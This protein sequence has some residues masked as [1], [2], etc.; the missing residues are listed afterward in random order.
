MK[1]KNRVIFGT[2]PETIK[3]A[4]WV[5]KFSEYSQN[6]ETKMWCVTAEHLEMLYQVSRVFNTVPDFVPVHEDT[7]TTMTIG[8][9]NFYSGA[10]VFYVEADLRIFD[11]RPPFPEEINRS[12]VLGVSNYHFVSTETLRNN[13][14]N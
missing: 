8:L 6:F 2:H 14:I 4:Q 13:L 3:M 11:K 1:K 7:T 5:N 12:I 10:K 9:A